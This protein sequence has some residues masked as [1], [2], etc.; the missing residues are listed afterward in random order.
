MYVLYFN[1]KQDVI[2]NVPPHWRDGVIEDTGSRWSGQVR[3]RN[4]ET[5]FAII[6]INTLLCTLL[7]P[8]ILVDCVLIILLLKI[9]IKKKQGLTIDSLIP[10]G[11]PDRIIQGK[12]VVDIEHFYRTNYPAHYRSANARVIERPMVPAPTAS[13]PSDEL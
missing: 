3:L 11:A 8:N 2:A 1:A 7:L 12:H 4:N 5:I 10:E 6:R 9:L 13:T